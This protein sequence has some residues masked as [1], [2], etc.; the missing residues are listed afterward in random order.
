V[1]EGRVRRGELPEFGDEEEAERPRET[2]ERIKLPGT[3]LVLDASGSGRTTIANLPKGEAPKE[4]LTELEFKDPNGEMQ[5]VSTRIPLWPS[6]YLVGIKADSWTTAKGPLNFQVAVLD[7]SGKPIAGAPVKVELL[8]RKT[9]SHRKRLVGGFYAYEHSAETKKIASVC[10]GATE[11][12]GLL[13][14]EAHSPVSGNVILQAQTIDAAGNP[15]IA[16]RD[17]WVYG[18]SDWWFEVGDHD[19]IDVLPDKRQYEPGE[20]ALFQVRM[21]FRKATALISVER[22]GVLEAYVR[23]IS[24]KNPVIPVAIQGAYAPNVF[25]S[26]LSV[27]GRVGG[28]KPTAMVDLGKPADKLGIAEIKVGWKDHEL[29]VTVSPERKV[30]RVREKVK[31]R[32]TVKTMDGKIPPPGSEVALAAVDEGLL[33]LMPNRSWQLLP[34][35]M[36]RRG[37]GVATATAQGQVIGKRHFGLKARPQGGGGGRQITRELF[38]A[39][40]LWKPRLPLDDHGEAWVEIPLNDSITGFRIVAIAT[41]GEGLFGTGFA[42]LQS[43]Q[44]L[45]IFSGLPPL[46]R[47]GDRFRGEFTFRNTTDRNL[48]VQISG[49]VAGLPKPLEPQTISLTPG[50]AKAISWGVVAPLGLESL[51]WEV[52]AAVFPS[53]PSRPPSLK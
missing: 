2:N 29:K 46:V 36:G 4:I 51:R 53:G 32:I 22:E 7:L 30:Y 40:L 52:E 15:T 18:K 19:R 6:R 33:E 50:E 34:A 37:Y 8:E 45:M 44:D 5:T 21:P 31:A 11:G 49:R 47:E 13:V 39:L 10:E 28:V 3:D 1:Q 38:D 41:A 26:V 17:I 42:S 24:G 9:F 23:R 14:C 25:V 16:H 12:S 20:T 27:S 35:M 48:E 43:T